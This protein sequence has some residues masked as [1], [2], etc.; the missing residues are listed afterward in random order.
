MIA[1]R[2]A[3]VIRADKLFRLILKTDLNKFK[4]ELYRKKLGIKNP[5]GDTDTKARMIS[6]GPFL[7]IFK[8]ETITFVTSLETAA[9]PLSRKRKKRQKK[10][11]SGST[12]GELSTLK[13]SVKTEPM[14][15]SGSNMVGGNGEVEDAIQ[16]KS[17][18][19]TKIEDK[20]GMIIVA[21]IDHDEISTVSVSPT[22]TSDSST[23]PSTPATT[24]E[25]TNEQTTLS[26]ISG[27]Y[28]SSS[29]NEK[30]SRRDRSRKS[31]KKKRS[32][33]RSLRYIK[34]VGGSPADTKSGSFC[35]ASS[36]SSSRSVLSTDTV[37]TSTTT[38]TEPERESTHERS[39]SNAESAVDIREVMQ[40][41]SL[42]QGNVK[43]KSL[44]QENSFS[45]M[46]SHP[47]SHMHNP[48]YYHD[49]CMHPQG[50]P[51]TIA[52]QNH[53]HHMTPSHM[54]Y[55][56]PP[57]HYN[58]MHWQQQLQGYEYYQHYHHHNNSNRG[59]NIE[60]EECFLIKGITLF[61]KNLFGIETKQELFESSHR[62][63]QKV[64]YPDTED[65]TLNYDHLQ[66][67]YLNSDFSYN[68]VEQE[69]KPGPLQPR[70]SRSISRVFDENDEYLEHIENAS[71][72]TGTNASDAKTQSTGRSLFDER[73]EDKENSSIIYPMPRTRIH[74]C[75]G[76]IEQSM[77]EWKAAGP[78]P[79]GPTLPITHD[80]SLEKTVKPRE[81][82][83]SQDVS[84]ESRSTTSSKSRRKDLNACRDKEAKQ[85][86]DETTSQKSFDSIDRTKNRRALKDNTSNT[87]R[88]RERRSSRTSS[89]D[90]KKKLLSRQMHRPKS[91]SSSSRSKTDS[92]GLP[93]KPLVR[94]SLTK[95][96]SA[97]SACSHSRSRSSVGA[98]HYR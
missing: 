18:K 60:Y 49:A 51:L 67:H 66:K 76:R 14:R 84:L 72:S 15:K 92:I 8:N 27:N 22:N 59:D 40:E 80:F 91:I 47:H 45:F 23:S 61:F 43:D 7:A 20:T 82:T 36:C 55:A 62:K 11:S 3:M 97:G 68:E 88:T 77:N 89:S 9:R 93:K 5:N 33:S 31:C 19:R 83:Y 63:S 86:I 85:R 65:N 96:T 39:P 41:N 56:Y 95:S 48:Y 26:L 90:R 46:P 81:R 57:P 69:P 94:P 87:P 30:K 2:D 79:S 71:E 28:S 74:S 17:P 4:I 64:C 54:M 25:K 52:G 44:W 12:S 24:L 10:G 16:S 58:T 21:E 6:R 73:N 37:S 38:F 53:H 32:K 42:W 29:F 75:E 78:R 50:H 34:S 70:R 13:L 98:F 1:D 35:D